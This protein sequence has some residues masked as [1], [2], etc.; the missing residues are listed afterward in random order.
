[1]KTFLNIFEDKSDLPDFS[2]EDLNSMVEE[3]TW[4]DIEDLYEPDELVSVDLDQDNIAEAIS[5]ASRLRKKM[6]FARHRAKRVRLRGVKLRRASDFST[7]KRRATGA[8]R[9]QIM[10]RLLRGRDKSTLSPSEKDRIESQLKRM[11][12]ITS[13]LAV[14]MVPKVRKLEQGRLYKKRK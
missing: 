12:N 3:L 6:S 13:I 11:K 2:E 1:M 5:A 10:K 14:K 4:A 8:A 9:R 7:L